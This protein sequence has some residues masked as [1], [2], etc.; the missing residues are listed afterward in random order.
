[1]AEY[2]QFLPEF[3]VVAQ[4]EQEHRAL[5]E[6]RATVETVLKAASG[7]VLA[8][9]MKPAP[10][11]EPPEPPKVDEP[12]AMIREAKRIFRRKGK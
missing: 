5:L 3:G 4:S 8:I 11:E 9:V 1:M 7:D 2:P 10:V 6:G 12:E